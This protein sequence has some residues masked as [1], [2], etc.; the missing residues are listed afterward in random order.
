MSVP[1]APEIVLPSSPDAVDADLFPQSDPNRGFRAF[2]R[3]REGAIGLALGAL[4]V[5]VIVVGPFVAPYA[6]D[7]VGL[8]FPAEDPSRAHWFGLD[9]LGR[10]VLSRV[11]SGGLS[12]LL[13]PLIAVGLTF[14]V[15]GVL[16]MA[17]GYV[18]GWLDAVLTRLTDILLAIPSVLA[19]LVIM[20]GLGTNYSIVVLAIAF[21]NCPSMFRVLRG[22]TQTVAPRDY[23]LAARAR[24]DTKRWIIFR[25][26]M[27]NIGPIIL[28]DC[29]LRTVYSTVFFATLSF[30]GLG[31]QPPS[32]NW[33][34]MVGENRAVIFTQP[35]ASLAPAAA[36]ALLAISINLI[37]DALAQYFGDE[38]TKHF[39]L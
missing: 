37:A 33:G 35:L 38:T 6:P 11:L 27:P 36:I 15:G 9:N 13:V 18:G 20:V 5:G 30:L 29:A 34:I 16:G 3:I 24:G 23:V 26:V 7:E 14:L 32:S 22:A 2:L 31:A 1:A 12:G 10:D 4:V 8:G 21:V 28:V 19:V 39:R 17:S 25:E